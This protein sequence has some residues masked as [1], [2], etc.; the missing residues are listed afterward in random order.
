MMEWHEGAYWGIGFGGFW[1]VLFWAAVIS[2][3]VWVVHKL[4]DKGE[5][6]TNTTII[7]KPMDIAKERYAKG[8][9]TQEEF[10]KLKKDLTK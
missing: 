7:T 1:M 8:E 2:F 4:T 6:L 10:L 5:V 3:G 9:I